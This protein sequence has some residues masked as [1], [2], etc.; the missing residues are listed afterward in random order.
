M[1]LYRLYLLGRA[2]L[3]LLWLGL[4]AIAH[5]IVC[6]LLLPLSWEAYLMERCRYAHDRCLE[7]HE[8]SLL[9]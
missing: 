6:R 3:W 5:T 4:L 9:A 2:V 8:E 7:L 1:N